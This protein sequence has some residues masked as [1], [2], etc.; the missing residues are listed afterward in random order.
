MIYLVLIV[1]GTL[2][3][4]TLSWLP[5]LGVSCISFLWVL[6]PPLLV[7]LVG[8]L[9]AVLLTVTLDTR[10]RGIRPLLSLN[11]CKRE[12]MSAL[13][14]K[15]WPL[16]STDLIDSPEVWEGGADSNTMVLLVNFEIFL[17]HEVSAL[18]TL[19][20]DLLQSEILLQ[21]TVVGGQIFHHL[22]LSSQ[23]SY[24]TVSCIVYYRPE[25]R[26]MKCCWALLCH[27]D[28][29]KGTQSTLLEHNIIDP[30]SVWATYHAITTHQKEQNA[31]SWS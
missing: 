6:S 8:W 21:W 27:K 24:C 11:S 28:T 31:P 20:L 15:V 26:I 7:S 25:W 1:A 19:Q 16:T 4:T 5:H 13:S 18:W 12:R 3:A 14:S 22:Q 10:C 30:F 23:S 2:T 29:A 9:A 17:L